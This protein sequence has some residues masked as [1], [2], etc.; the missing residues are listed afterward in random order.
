[1]AADQKA[2]RIVEVCRGGHVESRHLV[3]VVVA[4]AEGNLVQSH[5]DAEARIFPRSAIKALQALPLVESGA[6]DRFGFEPRH[7]A[8]ACASHN[9]APEHVD[10]A[11]EMLSLAGLAPVCLECGAQPPFLWRD[12]ARLVEAGEPLSALNNNC[13]GK[14]AG[15]LAFAAHSGFEPS[16]YIGID[17]PVQREIAGVLEAMTGAPHGPENHGIDGCSIPTY[18]L[19]LK[20]LAAGFARLAVAEDQG[21]ERQ[22]ALARIRDACLAHPGMIAGDE[23]FDTGFMRAMNKRVLTKTGAEGVF[24]ASIPELGYGIAIKCHDG[25]K[26]AAEVATAAIA[27]E[28]LKLDEAEL[29][30]IAP[31]TNPKLTNWN[32]F[33]VGELRM[34]AE[35]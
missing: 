2:P 25:E 15:F 30:A 4:D 14:H 11:G 35:N 22:K 24:A 19:P 21:P 13:S 9:G 31:F 7:L 8:L 5:G 23:R 1:M 6:A 26:R 3:D 28:L 33:V 17:H 20:A 16:G 34:A 12:H 18:Q 10:A 29:Q 32:G 27:A